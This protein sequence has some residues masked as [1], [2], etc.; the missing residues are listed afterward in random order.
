MPRA[1]QRLAWCLAAALAVVGCASQGP[2]VTEPPAVRVSRLA[3]TVITPDLIKFEAKVVIQNRS[4]S[5]L[6]LDRLD[7]AVDLMDR[8]LFKDS[9]A[10]LLRSKGRG[11][12][13]VTLPF[14]IAMKD[15]LA[16][17]VPILAEGQIRVGFRGTVFPLAFEPA[18]F[19]E[20]I[21]LPL[22]KIPEVT[23]A[24][25]DGTP[26]SDVFRVRLRVHNTNGFA[27]TVNSV[28]TH[29]DINQQRYPMLRTEQTTELAPGGIGTVTLRMENTPGKTLSMALSALQG[30]ALKLAVGG[31]IEC[32]SPYGWIVIP[33][34]VQN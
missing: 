2:A 19:R 24:G 11:S 30:Q 27:V 12:Q 31:T 14:Q 1:F 15:I 6:E 8:E 17:S 32:R 13:T 22:P 20:E 23:L 25:V 34:S 16:Q 9:F 21:R 5:A 10:D 18:P 7:Y 4:T 26:V 29:I 33:F 3:S 28:E